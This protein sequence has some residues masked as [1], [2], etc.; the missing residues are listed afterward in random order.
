[1]YWIIKYFFPINFL[2]R[3]LFL[4][5]NKLNYGT[6]SCRLQQTTDP[7]K[8]GKHRSDSAAASCSSLQTNVR[9]LRDN[10]VTFQSLVTA[11][12]VVGGPAGELCESVCVCVCVWMG[13][14]L[15]GSGMPECVYIESC[16]CV[17][18]S[19]VTMKGI[20][21]GP[22]SLHSWR[23]RVLRLFAVQ[24]NSDVISHAD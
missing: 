13:W 18:V 2:K 14:G 15:R 24:K 20:P 22:K 19:C 9:Q 3:P 17:C 1:M 10:C 12:I 5:L 16:V 6:D 8:W 23:T 7:L 4:L 21:L 11:C